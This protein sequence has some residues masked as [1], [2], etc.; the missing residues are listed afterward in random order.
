MSS[1]P[2]QLG[3]S[4]E[5]PPNARLVLQ[6]YTTISEHEVT[7]AVAPCQFGRQQILEGK[8]DTCPPLI[9]LSSKPGRE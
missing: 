6:Q 3:K 5:S 7:H 1:G 8:E 9:L 2:L 4:L